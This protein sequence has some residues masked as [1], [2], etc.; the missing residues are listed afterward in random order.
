MDRIERL[1]MALPIIQAPMAGAQG[2]ALAI[3]VSEAGGLSSLPG[4]MLSPD[5]LERELAVICR[6]TNE[7]FNARIPQDQGSADPPLA[8]TSP[9]LSSRSGRQW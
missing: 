1:G 3:A 5:M 2:S 9:M 7:P 8:T 6:A 4:A